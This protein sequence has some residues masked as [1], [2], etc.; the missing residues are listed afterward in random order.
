MVTSTGLAVMA[1]ALAVST[2]WASMPVPKDYV[3]CVIGGQ[4]ISADGYTIT[5]LDRAGRP[6]ALGAR[7]G[8]RL[9]VRGAL[10]PSDNL[11]LSAPPEDRGA[12][13]PPSPSRR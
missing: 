5:L 8:R 1:T 2:A 7:E 6:V 11:T 9:H 13:A 12:C 10:L 4:F 3:G